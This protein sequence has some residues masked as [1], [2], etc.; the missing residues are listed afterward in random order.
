MDTKTEQVDMDIKIAM[1]AASILEDTGNLSTLF[2]TLIKTIY[3][4]CRDKLL[5]IGVYIPYSQNEYP[6][7]FSLFKYALGFSAETFL[8]Y[9]V[10]HYNSHKKSQSYK[11]CICH[12]FSNN[13]VKHRAHFF[14]LSFFSLIFLLLFNFAYRVWFLSI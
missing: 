13:T 10:I 14:F 12:K 5:A 2:Q 7:P 4:K 3:N 1:V 8:S 9:K 11:V 6:Q